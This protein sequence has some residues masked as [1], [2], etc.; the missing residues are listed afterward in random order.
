MTPLH[1]Q[2]LQ[3]NHDESANLSLILSPLAE[4]WFKQLYKGYTPLAL[5]CMFRW[6]NDVVLTI[7][8]R[9]PN[10][11]AIS[12]PD[13]RDLPVHICAKYG[14]TVTVVEALLI[15][16]PHSLKLKSMSKS[17]LML[18]PLQHWTENVM[19]NEDVKTA[20]SR[21]VTHYARLKSLIQDSNN[22]HSR[23]Y[24]CSGINKYDSSSIAL[25]LEKVNDELKKSKS[26]EEVFKS[27]LHI[28][29]KKIERLSS[30]ERMNSLHSCPEA[31]SHRY[32]REHRRNLSK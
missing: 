27:R 29:E 12:N 11:S 24:N 28:L 25:E 6:Q 17:G 15:E 14:A 7:L 3:R 26:K 22:K 31:C 13:N 4:Q 23:Y 9:Y 5:A 30:Y 16:W 18:T 19:L 21:P 32:E 2:L 10:A 1:K 20:L 8:S